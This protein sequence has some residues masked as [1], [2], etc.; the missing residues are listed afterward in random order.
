[1]SDSSRHAYK[2]HTLDFYL[3]IYIWI[4]KHLKQN[5]MKNLI[6]SMICVIISMHLVFGYIFGEGFSPFDV[7][8]YYLFVML[9]V[10]VFLGIAFH[11]FDKAWNQQETMTLATNSKKTTKNPWFWILI[12]V[13][14]SLVIGIM[15]Y[16][17]Q[18]LLPIEE[19]SKRVKFAESPY[20][21]N[22]ICLITCLTGYVLCMIWLKKTLKKIWK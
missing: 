15:Y 10:I 8:G 4:Y 17:G 5:K 18:L 13:S 11:T 21:G 9:P 16:T 20:Y 3:L 6:R 2:K 12:I 19:I 22:L 14:T 1:M 7:S